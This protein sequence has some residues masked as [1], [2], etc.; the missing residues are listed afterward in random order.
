MKFN[1]L[2]SLSLKSVNE[3]LIKLEKSISQNSGG[4]SSY[5][6][7]VALLNQSGADDPVITE[8]ENT[9]GNMPVF[10]L[11][12]GKYRLF[13]DVGTRTENSKI[14]MSC[15]VNV[16][17]TT[18]NNFCAAVSV[19]NNDAVELVGYYRF[20]TL[21]STTRLIFQMDC[22]DK[23]FIAVDISTLTENEINL[24]EIRVYNPWWI[25]N[26]L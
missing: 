2:K 12:I 19:I 3:Q 6:S 14:W 15:G 25:E 13:G 17:P 18:D 5:L 1:P 9:I 4:G 10:R 7:F 16:K 20:Y 21:P 26:I 8:L 23:D 24:P 11:D 22:Y